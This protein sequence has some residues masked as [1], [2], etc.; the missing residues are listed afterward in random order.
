MSKPINLI[1][2]ATKNEFPEIAE[3]G[4]ILYDSWAAGKIPTIGLLE[5]IGLLGFIEFVA[6][7]ELLG[8]LSSEI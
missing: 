4:Q 5:F 1:L 3:L 8:L 2:S 6:F 7:V